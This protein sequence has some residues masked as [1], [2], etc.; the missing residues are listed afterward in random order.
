MTDPVNT[1]ATTD[2][3][4]DSV[5]DRG[6]VRG[7]E[8][9]VEVEVETE[10]DVDVDLGVTPSAAAPAACVAP[11]LQ[12]HWQ[13]WRELDVDRLYVLLRLRTQV[14]VVEQNC[15]FQDM[16]GYDAAS[17]H[18]CGIAGDGRVLAYARLLPPGL[19]Y[20]E[21]S[22]GRV[23]VDPSQRRSGL[24]RALMA[25]ALTGTAQRFPDAIVRL[26]AQQRLERF[27]ND[28]G[29]VAEGAPYLEDGIWH[30]DMLGRA[31]KPA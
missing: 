18:L 27:Y 4:A 26:G 20:P 12:W 29:F 13:T 8:A 23:V 2:S 11:A 9:N 30:I 14:F 15:V 22:I 7:T 21:A 25:Q 31:V 6:A 24:G 16:D 19:K 3:L 5:A 1:K 10:I 17:E 28:F